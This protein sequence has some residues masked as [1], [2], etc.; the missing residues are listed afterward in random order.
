M[1]TVAIDHLPSATHA[2]NRPPRADV[3]ACHCRDRAL[4]ALGE[5]AALAQGL[6]IHDLDIWRGLTLLEARLSGEPLAHDRHW[7][8]NVH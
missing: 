6:G 5:L 7:L 8:G 3:G 4:A 2:A 1:P